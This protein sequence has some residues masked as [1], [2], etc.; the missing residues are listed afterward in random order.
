METR[1]EGECI[2]YVQRLVRQGAVLAGQVTRSTGS[3]GRPGK[4]PGEIIISGKSNSS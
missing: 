3:T 1:V 4:T 2:L